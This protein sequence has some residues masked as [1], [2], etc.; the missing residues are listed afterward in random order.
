MKKVILTGGS[1]F[2][3]RNAIAG[4]LSRDYE[5]HLFDIVSPSNFPE[6]VVVHECDLF[7]SQ[8]QKE[9][10]QKI[11]A[12]HL[13]HFAWYVVP[14]KF[15]TSTENVRWVQ[16]SLEL[17]QNFEKHGGKRVV[18]T[19]TCAEYDWSDGFC[20]EFNTPL[21]PKTLYGV[22]K[23]SL[24]QIYTAF[25]C[26]KKLSNAWGRIFFL[27]GP[28]ENPQRLVPSAIQ[29]LLAD[30]Q[31]SCT[32]GCQVLD[33]MHVLDVATAFVALL[34]SQVQGPV[35][36]A[37]G[38]SV[39]VKE[40][41]EKIAQKIGKKHL[42]KLGTLPLSEEEPMVLKADTKRLQDEVGWKPHFTID[43]VL[44]DTI[45]WWKNA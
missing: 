24:Q 27:F 45:N 29:A 18:F 10:L 3:G 1:G 5:I 37:S 22:C 42:I 34:D 13:L 21:I 36:I 9:L 41:V 32:H 35:N 26:E 20:S 30:R 19:G 39:T 38:Q 4:L 7:D 2:I 25:C 6:G 43:N 17:L 33:V 16:A 8:Q 44:D 14:G 11:K 40:I 23:N 15:W 12:T 31:F 28:Y